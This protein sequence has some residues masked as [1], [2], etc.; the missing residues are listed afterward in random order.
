MDVDSPIDG[1]TGF[2]IEDYI[3]KLQIDS[4]PSADIY[5]SLRLK[6]GYTEQTSEQTYL[7]VTDADF[8][9][10]PF[11]RYAA[12]EGDVIQERTRA[13]PTQLCRRSRQQLA[14]IGNRIP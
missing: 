10:D 1:D 13:V 4:D 7:G 6:L 5:Q 3:A 12:S 8:E 9:S 11:D 14:R 2:E